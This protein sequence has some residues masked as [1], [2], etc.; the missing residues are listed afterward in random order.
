MNKEYLDLIQKE[1]HSIRKESDVELFSSFSNLMFT[2]FFD[3]RHKFISIPSLDLPDALRHGINLIENVFWFI[4]THTYNL[5]LTLFLTERAKLLFTEF[6]VMSRT[7]LIMKEID[8]FPSLQDAFQFAIKRSIGSIAP[9]KKHSHFP[10]SFESKRLFFKRLLF[11]LGEKLQ[12]DSSIMDGISQ[13]CIVE[14]QPSLLKHL[15]IHLS[16]YHTLLT[17]QLLNSCNAYSFIFLIKLI[18]LLYLPIDSV[19]IEDILQFFHFHL[20]S[21]QQFTQNELSNRAH[22]LLV[23]WEDQLLL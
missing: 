19:N 17:S 3:I 22:F 21:F 20:S 9:I 4:Y 10:P 12:S 8:K 18:S 16:F 5:Q 11:T 2:S 13:F 7:Q 1:K 6:I 14:L 15:D 23:E